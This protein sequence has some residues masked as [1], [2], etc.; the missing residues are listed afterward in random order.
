MRARLFVPLLVLACLVGWWISPGRA[1]GAGIHRPSLE[2]TAHRVLVRE[3]MREC[4]YDEA[5]GGPC[6]WNAREDGNGSGL[7]FWVNRNDR[8][9]YV[10]LYDPTA[11]D[12]GWS[13]VTPREDRRLD[14]HR[15]PRVWT[16]C[17]TYSGYAACP[18]RPGVFT[19]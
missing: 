16:R 2:V 10:W 18:W 1:F 12:F 4:R 17:A 9:R 7:S 14:R 6:F 19:L 11:G 3:S 8:I 13:W 15:H 5:A